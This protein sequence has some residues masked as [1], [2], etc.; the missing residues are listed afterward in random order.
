M[1]HS[2]TIIWPLWGRV[3]A[4]LVTALLSLSSCSETDDTVEE[5]PDW[6]AKN[7]AFFTSKYSMVSQYVAAGYTDWKIIRGYNLGDATGNVSPTDN[8]LVHVLRQGTGSGCPLYSDTVRVHYRGQLI[9]STTYV[10][11]S[12]SELGLVFDK[13]WSTDVFNEQISI[14]SKM[15]VGG[16]VPGFSTALQY[17]HIGDRW[18]IYVPYQ[19]AY[20][21]SNNGSIPAYSTLVFD[22]ALAAYYH[23]GK[24]V[25][26]WSANEA[27]LW[28]EAP[29]E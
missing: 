20:G 14:P 9:A 19:L 8:I 13:S 2:T 18:R 27:A 16:L 21:T 29:E 11:S 1:R 23:P 25:P 10:D 6:K 12:D 15:G 5:F 28:D 7:E 22:I 3:F 26:D 17:M 4:L 24:T